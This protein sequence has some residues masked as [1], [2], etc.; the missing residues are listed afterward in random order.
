MASFP[1]QPLSWLTKF[2]DKA[3]P[4]FIK[5]LG[6]AI[7]WL[8]KEV[9]KPAFV[10]KVEGIVGMIG[11]L[12]SAF[13]GLLSGL[14]GFARWLGVTSPSGSSDFS[15]GTQPGSGRGGETSLEGRHGGHGSGHFR[16][17][18]SHGGGGG[19]ADSG[20][21]AHHH[22]S[23][24]ANLAP[25]MAAMEDQ[26]R[27]EGVPEANVHAAAALM[28]GQAL[29]E[30]PLNPD[31]L[32]DFIHGVPTG[33]GIYGARLDRRTRMLAWEA[34][35]G[36]AR[37]SL[38]GQARQMGHDAMT[39]PEYAPTRRELMRAT[40]GSIGSATRVITPNFEGPHVDNSGKRIPNVRSALQIHAAPGG[41]TSLS[42]GAVAAGSP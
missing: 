8:A 23:A 37:N 42:S 26:L 15:S 31:E 19:G 12:A 30:S 7:D 24:Q 41:N 11:S 38:E 32:H 3:L 14:G 34:A 33:Y 18:R 40:E 13:G 20:G 21:T 10:E 1:R 27:R 22:G 4:V 9:E 39:R 5:D 36:Y 28:V 6:G 29:S 2:T 25:A 16:H 17:G 35:H